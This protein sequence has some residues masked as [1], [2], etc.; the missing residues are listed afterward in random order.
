LGARG[1][2][3]DMALLL[4]LNPLGV[5]S[6]QL[7]LGK[8]LRTKYHLSTTLSLL[9]VLVE[10]S[11]PLALEWRNS[12]SLRLAISYDQDHQSKSSLMHQPWAS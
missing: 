3:E 6:M 9:D 7:K 12:T 8:T 1:A 2:D 10:S 4:L 5:F 11:S